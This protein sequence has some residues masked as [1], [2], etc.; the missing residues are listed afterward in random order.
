MKNFGIYNSQSVN[1]FIGCLLSIYA[2]HIENDYSKHLKNLKEKDIALFDIV[3]EFWKSWEK[4]DIENIN[5]NNSDFELI[6][7]FIYN[8]RAWASNKKIR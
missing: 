7:N 6:G 4:F 3:I 5:A 8:I 2:D 1:L